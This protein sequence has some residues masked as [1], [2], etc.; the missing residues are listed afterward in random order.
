MPALN[1]LAKQLTELAFVMAFLNHLGCTSK[2]KYEGTARHLHECLQMSREG[3]WWA[4]GS[5][6]LVAAGEKGRSDCLA[7]LQFRYHRVVDRG[8][9]SSDA[10]L[11]R[12]RQSVHVGGFQW[13]NFAAEAGMDD[14]H[15]G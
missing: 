1:L 7:V 12:S 9:W 4:A 5:A 6:F 11:T 15:L 14:R 3:W 10:T 8:S 2:L 13:V